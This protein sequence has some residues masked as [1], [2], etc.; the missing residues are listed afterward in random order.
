MLT[1]PEVIGSAHWQIVGTVEDAVEEIVEWRNAGAI[2]GFIAV[3]G[4]SVGSLHRVLE[5]L[6]PRLAEAGLFRK[7]Y[8]GATFFGHLQE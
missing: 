2:D 7:E 5:E 6:V 4:G 3:P 1:R 8:L